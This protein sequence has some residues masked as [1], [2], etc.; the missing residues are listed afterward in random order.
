MP[1]ARGAK[2]NESARDQTT[3]QFPLVLPLRPWSSSQVSRSASL[4][5]AH[6]RS[7]MQVRSNPA[8]VPVRTVFLQTTFSGASA[9][10]I[11]AGE[12]KTVV[13]AGNFQVITP[14]LLRTCE[15]DSPVSGLNCALSVMSLHVSWSSSGWP[16]LRVTSQPV[17]SPLLSSVTVNP[18]VPSSRAASARGG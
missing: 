1:S 13:L 12:G 10:L 6:S 2:D 8:N 11:G 18:T 7:V 9:A 4:C 3:V 14:S 16:L 5:R 17:T 15:G